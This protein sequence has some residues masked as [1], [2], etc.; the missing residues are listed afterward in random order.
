MIKI[1]SHTWIDLV[2][3]GA[4][5]LG[6]SVNHDQA[7]QFAQHGLWL[8][9]WNRRINLTAITDPVQIAAKH[10][11]DAIAPLNHIPDQG[12]LLDIGTGG[13]FP[14]IPLKILRPGQPMTLIDS[15]RKKINF[16]KHV[17]RQLSL[18]DIQ[19]HHTRAEEL[20]EN[21]SGPDRYPVVVCRALA[22]LERAVRLAAP[23]LAS[24][25]RIVLYQG[26]RKYAENMALSPCVYSLDGR[27]YR[28]SVFSYSLPVFGDPRIITILDLERG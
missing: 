6:V 24:K 7:G 11:L 18:N 9:E 23:L 16:V 20:S 28:R 5:R 19:A 22:D 12:H 13:G 26:P 3:E 17:I 14:G 2:R 1:G 25:G 8:M 21:T 4:S 10:F 27:T 15:V